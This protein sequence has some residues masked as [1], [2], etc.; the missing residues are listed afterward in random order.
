MLSPLSSTLALALATGAQALSGTSPFLL[1]ST[2]PLH[3]PAIRSTQFSTAPHVQQAVLETLSTCKAQL[4]V[5][6]SHPG[7]NEADFADTEAMPAMRSRVLKS[8]GPYHDVVQIPEVVGDI[9]VETI[10]SGLERSCGVQRI[11]LDSNRESQ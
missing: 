7:L 4:Y 1:L 8:S 3:Q 5:V 6:V 11:S 10:V 2:E 9:D